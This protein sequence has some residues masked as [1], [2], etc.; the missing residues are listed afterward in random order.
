MSTPPET[1]VWAYRAH[2]DGLRALAVYLV[3]A[4]HAGVVRASGGFVG[5]DVFF[6]L[7]GYLV[8]GV[9]VRD[10]DGPRGR[11]GFGRFY[12][13]RVRRLLPA[14][15]VN[16]V[17]TAVVFG[18][19]AAPVEL[20]DAQRAIRAAALYV[21]NWH[22]IAQSADYFAAD[23]ETSPV[24]HYWSLSVEEQFYVAWP[25][26]LAGIYALARRRRRG[27]AAGAGGDRA[28]RR[29]LLRAGADPG[30][31]RHQ[32]GLPGH[33]HPRVPTPGR[34]APRG[35]AGDRGPARSVACCCGVA[36]GGRD[37]GRGRGHRGHQPGRDRC[38]LAGPR[39]HRGHRRPD[40]LPR[41]GT[42]RSGA[43]AVLLGARGVPGQDLLRHLPVA[44]DRDRGARPR[45]RARPRGHRRRGR[46]GGHRAGLAQLRAAGAPHPHRHRASTASVPWSSPRASC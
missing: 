37:P 35:H 5:V 45:G 24:A 22:F 1:P 20:A 8:T 31:S 33:R 10:L 15:A 19:V 34:R 39:H 4:F 30:R 12:A 23:V 16:L 27:S 32:P 9:L 26:L 36:D 2:L 29:G 46:R 14:A 13:R 43:S 44:L 38:H 40:R 7:S 6:V 17:V 42:W 18:V 3:V 25:L 11:V 21:A 28:G 41:R